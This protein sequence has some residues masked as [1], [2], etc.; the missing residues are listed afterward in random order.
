VSSPPPP[1]SVIGYSPQLDALRAF[2]VTAVLLNHFWLEQSFWGHWGVRLFFVLSGYLV[3]AILLDARDRITDSGGVWG[4]WKAFYI[5]RALRIFP[6]YYLLLAVVFLSSAEARADWPWHVFYGTNLLIAL[7]NDWG[8]RALA[9]LWSLSVEEQFYLVWPFVV[10][11]VPR[12][13]LLPL[14]VMLILSALGFRYALTSLDGGPIRYVLLPSALDVLVGGALLAEL[15]RRGYLTWQNIRSIVGLGGLGIAL[16]FLT[17]ATAQDRATVYVLSGFFLALPM[18]AA[19]A[20]CRLGLPGLPGRVLEMPWLVYLGRISYG[21]YLF[22]YPVAWLLAHLLR[23]ADYLFPPAGLGQFVLA[24]A[25]TV[26]IAVLSF[27]FV[28]QPINGL[29]H[30]FRYTEPAR[31]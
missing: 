7:E 13:W 27:R 25:A 21:I 28:E 15:D 3:T 26:I 19:V 4:I 5:R 23:E 1:P 12:R 22:H 11:L 31:A 6:A 10:L 24:S 14:F 8:F 18:I 9:H 16:Y 30:R 17:A 2:A 20:V 29:K